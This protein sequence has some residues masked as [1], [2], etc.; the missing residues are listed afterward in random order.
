MY[1]TACRVLL[2]LIQPS[3]RS[4]QPRTAPQTLP[5]ESGAAEGFPDAALASWRRKGEIVSALDC[6]NQLQHSLS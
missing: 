2:L 3:A 1:K 4:R 6:Q 5:A